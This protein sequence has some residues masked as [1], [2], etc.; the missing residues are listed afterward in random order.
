MGREM[1][2]E[3]HY[4]HL[5]HSGLPQVQGVT[6]KIR[7][8][9]ASTLA[10]PSIPRDHVDGGGAIILPTDMVEVD[11]TVVEADLE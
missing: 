9:D 11:R 1:N 2:M 3:I 8:C 6:L 4:H 7:K 5:L 10:R